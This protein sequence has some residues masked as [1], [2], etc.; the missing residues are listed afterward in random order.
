MNTST[1]EKT[2]EQKEKR[3][4]LI[5]GIVLMISALLLNPFVFGYMLAED[6]SIDQQS[7]V[8]IILFFE[9]VLLVLG[10]SI[11]FLTPKKLIKK[12][13]EILLLLI[14]IFLLFLSLELLLHIYPLLFGRN[15]TNTVLGKYHTGDDGIYYFDAETNMTFLKPNFTTTNY[16]NGYIW[17]H[18]TDSKGFR[19][20]EEREHADIILLG[21]SLVYGHG[22]EINQTIGYFIETFGGST[23]TNLARQGDTSYQ[24]MY[25]LNQYGVEYNPIYVIYFFAENDISDLY[26]HNINRESFLLASKEQM[27]FLTK[28]P[29]MWQKDKEESSVKKVFGFLKKSYILRGIKMILQTKNAEQRKMLQNEEEGW[30]YTEKAIKLMKNITEENNATF[31][32]MPLTPSNQDMFK[33]L[34]AFAEREHI[35]FVNTSSINVQNTTLFLSGD[36]HFSEEGA[37]AVARLAVNYLE[38]FEMNKE[39]ISS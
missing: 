3:Q 37:H 34:G 2:D 10:I 39:V 38:A 5:I 15:F 35:H 8:L 23:T 29:G 22:V 18:K 6:G 27:T 19:N 14:I 7:V 26:V 21:D 13:K 32:M 9:G 24:Q 33:R 28:A 1:L 12:K 16:Y 11:Y 17:E 31:I 20:I 30:L 25:L 36:G 4:I